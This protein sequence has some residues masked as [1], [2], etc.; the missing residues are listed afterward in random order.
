M[1][2]KFC[3]RFTIKRLSNLDGPPSDSR[4]EL[5]EYLCQD[6]CL[7]EKRKVAK[8]RYHVRQEVVDCNHGVVFVRTNTTIK[9]MERGR[10]ARVIERVEPKAWFRL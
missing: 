2:C 3:Q 4:L 10:N 9:A 1:L 8:F 7:P 6:A 5:E